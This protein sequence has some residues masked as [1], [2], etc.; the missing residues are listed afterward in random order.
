MALPEGGAGAGVQNAGVPREEGDVVEISAAS[1]GSSLGTPQL[2]HAN[3]SPGGRSV[4]VPRLPYMRTL[5]TVTVV[6]TDIVGY[7]AMSFTLPPVKVLKMLHEYFTKLDALMDLAGTFKYQVMIRDTGGQRLSRLVP[8]LL[9][10]GV[11]G[12]SSRRRW[13]TLTSSWLA[14]RTHR[15]TTP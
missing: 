10:T 13:E 6:F 5:E 3:W 9:R 15:W 12:L 7:T 8:R 14:T 11:A 4:V 1:L 2:I